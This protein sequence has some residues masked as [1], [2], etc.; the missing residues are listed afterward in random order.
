MP[1]QSCRLRISQGNVGAADVAAGLGAVDDRDASAPDDGPA[2]A[3][4]GERGPAVDT[5]ERHV[6]RD[7]AFEAAEELHPKLVEVRYDRQA[8]NQAEGRTQAPD[9]RKVDHP[10]PEHHRPGGTPG[11]DAAAVEDAD[12]RL[13][14]RAIS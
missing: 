6:A 1:G 2:I 11:D 13:P 14:A 5:D 7:E 12:D 8:A 4:A 3:G 10:L 9:L